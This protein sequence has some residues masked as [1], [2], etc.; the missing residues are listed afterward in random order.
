MGE[1]FPGLSDPQRVQVEKQL[2]AQSHEDLLVDI[3]LGDL[4]FRDFI[5]LKNVLNPTVMVA[6][7]FAKHLYENNTLFKDKTVFDVGT[8]SGLQGIVCASTGARTVVCGDLTEHATRNA[9]LN[10][11]RCKLENAHAVQSDLFENLPGTADVIL[12]NHPF[13]PTKPLSDSPVSI[14]MFDEGGLLKR[15]LNEAKKRLNPKG[16]IIMPYYEIAG[17]I[18]DPEKVGRELGYEVDVRYEDVSQGTQTGRVKI[19]YLRTTK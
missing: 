9:S 7:T 16:I 18:N 6:S 4:Y 5:V 13:F 8:G 3:S 2:Q 10:I 11:E 14:A 17:D 19:C 12:F 1:K 15:F